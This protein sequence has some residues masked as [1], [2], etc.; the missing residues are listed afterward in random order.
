M[1]L[2]PGQQAFAWAYGSTIGNST[3]RLLLLTLLMNAKPH[4]PGEVVCDLSLTELAQ[5]CEIN[6][7]TAWK[8]VRALADAGVIRAIDRRPEPSRLFVRYDRM[9]VDLTAGGGA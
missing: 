8:A 4:Q 6:R 1:S 7:T 9:R 3:W 2:T 5:H